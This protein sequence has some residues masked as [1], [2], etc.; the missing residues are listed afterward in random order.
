MCVTCVS[1]TPPPPR[2]ALARV[3]NNN[4]INLDAVYGC[5]PPETA[6]NKII[7]SNEIRRNAKAA[8]SGIPAILILTK[9]VR[10]INGYK[11]QYENMT[12]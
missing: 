2:T 11:K 7:I 9:H 12:G 5:F 8:S 4:V 3:N 10:Y 1:F 6:L